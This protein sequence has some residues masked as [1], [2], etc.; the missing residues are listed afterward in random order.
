[1]NSK[2]SK[3]CSITPISQ[4]LFANDVKRC[5]DWT[6]SIDIY[7]TDQPDRNWSNIFYTQAAEADGNDLVFGARLPALFARY[8]TIGEEKINIAVGTDLNDNFN[9]GFEFEI[10]KFTWI[11]IKIREIGGL[12][13]VAVNNEIIHSAM[14]DTPREWASV[15]VE[16]GKQIKMYLMPPTEGNYRNFWF[17]LC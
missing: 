7:L 13:S 3:S 1:M 15:S 10:L 14:N 12:Y 8:G 4:T 2:P 11:N 9:Y 5:K 6:I 16:M 17:D